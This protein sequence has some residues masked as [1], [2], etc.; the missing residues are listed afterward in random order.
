MPWLLW[1][2]KLYGNIQHWIK[3]FSW[4]HF[5]A[6]NSHDKW[7]WLNYRLLR[8][9]IKYDLFRKTYKKLFADL[10]W[11]SESIVSSDSYEQ[12]KETR[13]NQLMNASFGSDKSRDST[14]HSAVERGNATHSVIAK[15]YVSQLRGRDIPETSGSPRSRSASVRMDETQHL[16][17]EVIEANWVPTDV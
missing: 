15:T 12:I 17:W 8:H 5:F 7:L 16:P 10:L 4:N 13:V 6:S 11:P 14:T 3:T 9:I 2:S 1:S